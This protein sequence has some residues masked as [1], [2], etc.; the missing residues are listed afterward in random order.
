MKE[1]WKLWLTAI[2]CVI[3]MSFSSQRAY[4]AFHERPPDWVKTED[5]VG[6]AIS[7][8]GQLSV[9]WK[10]FSDLLGTVHRESAQQQLPVGGVSLLALEADVTNTLSIVTE[11]MMNQGFNPLKNVQASIGGDEKRFVGF[12]ATDGAPIPFTIVRVKGR[13]RNPPVTLHLN[14]PIAPAET[15]WVVR[16]ERR[17]GPVNIGKD[18]KAQAGLG[19][20]PRT[21]NAIYARAIGLPPGSTI[22]RSV[23]ATTATVAEGVAPLVSW[24]GTATNANAPMS[25]AFTPPK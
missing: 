3:V 21:P 24:I 8:D 25:V 20:F 10:E 4:N 13:Q 14:T 15:Q 18:G 6:P 17:R 5:R 19:R 16:V 23:P 2:A 7:R 1:H 11:P 12:Y 22:V 9:A